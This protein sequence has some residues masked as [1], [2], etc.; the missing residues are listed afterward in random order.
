VP[1]KSRLGLHSLQK[2]R[3][4]TTSSSMTNER[5]GTRQTGS[6]RGVGSQ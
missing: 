4:A 1:F 5:S 2:L 6:R 3:G